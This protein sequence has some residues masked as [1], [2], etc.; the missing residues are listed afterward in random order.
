[1]KDVYVLTTHVMNGTV[2]IMTRSACFMSEELAKDVG[3]AIDEANKKNGVSTF[4]TIEATTVYESRDEVPI[5]KE[6]V[7]E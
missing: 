6:V 1:M 4:N 5:L 3:D 7:N 2:T